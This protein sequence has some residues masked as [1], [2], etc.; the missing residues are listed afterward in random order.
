MTP[1]TP[2]LSAVCR[3]YRLALP[4]MMDADLARHPAVCPAC[5]GYAAALTDARAR[6]PLPAAL[7]QRLLA[8]PAAVPT[9]GPAPGDPAST[10]PAAD[11]LPRAPLPPSLRDRLLAIPREAAPAAAPRRPSWWLETR[12]LLAASY[13]L[14]C[15]VS[16]LL[17]GFQAFGE[18]AVDSGARLA[19][20]VR[21]SVADLQGAGE[22]GPGRLRR[23]VAPLQDSLEPL[24]VPALTA[25]PWVGPLRDLNDKAT[26]AWD[27]WQRHWRR[28]RPAADP[29]SLETPIETPRPPAAQPR[30]DEDDNSSPE[31][32]AHA[33][34][35]L[36]EALSWT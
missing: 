33:A 9:A 22:Q 4:G 35:L 2:E 19:S 25:E 6:V 18:H 13:L 31:G 23:A 7:R 16:G 21:T 34:P 29:Q 15:L 36:Y 5:A 20:A 3:R 1:N 26:A 17:G 32:Q 27:G 24:E 12:P 11:P 14:A 10:A 30:P 28:E 8:V